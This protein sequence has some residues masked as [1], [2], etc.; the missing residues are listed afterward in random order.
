MLMMFNI[1]QIYLTE[2]LYV[3]YDL[4][5]YIIPLLSLEL[6]IS[7]GKGQVFPEQ[8]MEVYRE[9]R[10]IA[11]LILSL[12]TIKLFISINIKVK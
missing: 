1:R 7:K 5:L 6:F 4:S 10:G 3:F 2:F 8:T 9:S 12:G 11:P